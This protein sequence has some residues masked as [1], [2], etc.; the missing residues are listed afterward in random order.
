[1]A[2]QVKD[3]RTVS[4]GEGDA[5]LVLRRDGANE[6]VGAY[7]NPEDPLSRTALLAIAFFYALRN[8]KLLDLIRENFEAQWKADEGS[9]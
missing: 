6:V 4:L 5:A 9:A 2:G 1:M 3:A 7:A 8:D